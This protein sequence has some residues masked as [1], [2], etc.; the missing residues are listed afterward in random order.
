MIKKFF[1]LIIFLLL[2]PLIIFFLF[3]NLITYKNFPIFLQKRYG[4]NKK[5]FLLIK[6]KSFFFKSNK[7]IKINNFIRKT[8]LD[9]LLQIINIIKNDM[10]YIGVRPITLEEYNYLDYNLSDYYKFHLRRRFDRKPGIFGLSQI[11][12]YGFKIKSDNQNFLKDQKKKIFF[13]YIFTKYFNI[14]LL[15]FIILC[16]P[17]SLLFPRSKHITFILFK[18]KR[19]IIKKK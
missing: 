1:S 14:N 4:I 12:N 18:F 16:T 15:I 3:L 2:S 13:D 17:I 5:I 9:E 8:H 7:I 6:I 10:N 11:L 19:H